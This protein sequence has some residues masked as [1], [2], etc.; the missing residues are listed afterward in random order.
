MRY[1]FPV[2]KEV[3]LLPNDHKTSAIVSMF[4]WALKS[5]P[6]LVR[7]AL[8]NIVGKPCVFLM[9]IMSSHQGSPL[10]RES[11]RMERSQR[12]W[13][14]W[15]VQLELGCIA[16]HLAISIRGQRFQIQNLRLKTPV[17]TKRFGNLAQRK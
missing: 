13:H 10:S 17:F 15:V 14:E 9:F 12:G 6:L 2:P 3:S 16:A 4:C 5:C 8:D 7:G 1:N 11:L